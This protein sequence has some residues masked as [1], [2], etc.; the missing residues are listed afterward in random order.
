[1][2]TNKEAVYDKRALA[3]VFGR[4]VGRGVPACAITVTSAPERP[5]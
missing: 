3:A 4:G 2:A 5:Q 1:M